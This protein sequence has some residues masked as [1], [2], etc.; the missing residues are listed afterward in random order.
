LN[1]LLVYSL[2]GV[3]FVDYEGTIGQ[4]PEVG[5]AEPETVFIFFFS[6]LKIHWPGF[7]KENKLVNKS[8]KACT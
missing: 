7:T 6:V 4:S 3:Y 8:L 5:A 2:W 1:V